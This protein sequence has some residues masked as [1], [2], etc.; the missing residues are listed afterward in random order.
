M[1][2]TH[3]FMKQNEWAYNQ[4]VNVLSEASQVYL[5]LMSQL[6]EIQQLNPGIL[7]YIALLMLVS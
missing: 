2:A 6:T 4:Q 3:P 7:L 5:F 1:L